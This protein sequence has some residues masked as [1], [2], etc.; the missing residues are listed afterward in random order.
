MKSINHTLKL[1][2]L[3]IVF[4]FF[5]RVPCIRTGGIRF[6]FQGNGYWLLVFVMN[7]GGAGDIASMAVKGSRT[8]WI[9]MS[10]N[11]G[12]SYQAFSS[13]GGQSLS[14]QITS[15]T[16]KQTIIAYNVAPSNWQVGMTYQAN[17][18]FH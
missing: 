13:L 1:V 10:H 8:G 6:S 9:N 11:W 2:L 16:T 18:N 3:K 5:C 14:F 4:A 15:Y 7:V 17:V 12:A